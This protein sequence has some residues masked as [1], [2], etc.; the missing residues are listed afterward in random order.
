MCEGWCPLIDILWYPSTHPTNLKQLIQFQTTMKSTRC[1][2]WVAGRLCHCN[3]RISCL[4]SLSLFLIILF[5]KASCLFTVM[6]WYVKILAWW[7]RFSCSGISEFEVKLGSQ[8]SQAP[9][10]GIPS[11]PPS[12]RPPLRKL[13]IVVWLQYFEQQIWHTSAIKV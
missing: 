1:L 13:C 3:A 7:L 12:T 9:T 6:Q 5:L 8:V 4:Y 2:S 10:V 11:V